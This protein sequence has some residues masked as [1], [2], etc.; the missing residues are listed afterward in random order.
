M[1]FLYEY[2]LFIAKAVTIVI[3]I[4]LALGGIVGIVS[5]Q[6]QGKGHLEIDSL[7]DKLDAITDL[8]R[9]ELLTK[10]ELKQYQKEQKKKQKTEKKGKKKSDDSEADK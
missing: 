6:K 8:A 2:G 7:S 4:L 10:E 9:G 3:A 5:K 1:E